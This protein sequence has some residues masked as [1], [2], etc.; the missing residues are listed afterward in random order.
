[1]TLNRAITELA[2]LKARLAKAEIERDTWRAAHRQENYLEA[3]S[4]VDALEMQ[5]AEVEGAAR[6]AA[7]SAPTPAELCISFN[8]RSYGYRGYRYDRFTDAIDY[9]RL[10]RSR[11]FG[12][13]ALDG[14]AL[15]EPVPLPSAAEVV[16][17][18][19]LGITFAGGV[20][21]W[22]EYRYDRL[23]DAVAYARRDESL[24]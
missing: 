13:V 17:M 14:G 3:C 22:R 10:D 8:G 16:L 6:A 7:A 12:D 15:L 18:R 2:G 4:M 24:N 9:A 19:S 5:I 11:P 20:F 23:A 21:H 1:M